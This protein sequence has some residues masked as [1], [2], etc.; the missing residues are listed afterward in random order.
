MAGTADI[1]GHAILL[2]RLVAQMDDR[3]AALP[4]R[5]DKLEPTPSTRL[6]VVVLEEFPGL[7]RAAG[8]LPKP[9]R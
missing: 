2:E 5:V 6:F 3:L 7:L 1:D 9:A 4:D 8:A